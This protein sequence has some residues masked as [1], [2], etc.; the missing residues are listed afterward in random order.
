[1]ADI[2]QFTQRLKFVK[3]KDI[4]AVFPMIGAFIA[5]VPF[6]AFHKNIWL[7]C[8]REND[9]RDNGYWFFKYLCENH[10]EIESVYAINKQ[11]VDYKK[12]AKLGKVIQFGSFKHWLYYFAAKKNVSSQKEGKPNAALCFVLEVY[13]GFRKNRFYLKHGITKDAQRWI[14]Y[15][16]AKFSMISTSSKREQQ[17]VRENFGYPNAAIQLVGMCRF[18]N[19][20]SP[21]ETKHQILVMP[22]MREWLREI[23]SDTLK[24][25]GTKDITKSEFFRAW[26]CFL[27]NH[28]LQQILEHFQINLIFYLHPSMQQYSKLFETDSERIRIGKNT[29]YDMQEL[30]MESS[31]LITDYSSIFFDFAYMEKP[32]LFYQF[33]Y[34]KYRR[35]Q[36]Q[37]GYFSYKSDGFG[38]VVKDENKLLQELKSLLTNHEIM[39]DTYKKRVDDFFAFRDAMNCKRNYDAISSIK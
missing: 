25:E 32:M 10:P 22:T 35:G 33:D 7:V 9:A 37:E 21:H 4:M 11:S 17:F 15:D 39:P 19:L 6:K 28:E 2:K 12:V 29:E 1:M 3:K 18:D 31:V 8:E 27:N 23:S 13:L 16:V 26:I 24:Y 38:A 5:S 36:Y 20:L 14:Y 30:L 34:E